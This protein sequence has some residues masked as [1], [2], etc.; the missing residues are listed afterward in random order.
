[1]TTSSSLLSRFSSTPPPGP[2]H[3]H[4]SSPRPTVADTFLLH[5]PLSPLPLVVVS[6]HYARSQPHLSSIYSTYSTRLTQASTQRS[7]SLP[8]LKHNTYF[9][10]RPR[11]VRNMS[12]LIA[13]SF[14]GGVK[15][16]TPSCRNIPPEE[17]EATSSFPASNHWKHVSFFRLLRH[18]HLPSG[19]KATH[20]SSIQPPT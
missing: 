12:S 14:V 2:P 3:A 4:S 6:P 11:T 18:P 7:P 9:Q 5:S 20:T 19:C 10:T 15:S 16:W 13:G 1:M 17:Q 8:A